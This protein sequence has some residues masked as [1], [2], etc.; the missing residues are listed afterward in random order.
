MHHPRDRIVNITAFVIPVVNHWLERLS[1][2]TCISIHVHG[3][4]LTLNLLIIKTYINFNLYYF[5]LLSVGQISFDLM[6]NIYFYIH[7]YFLIK[8]C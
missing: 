3:Y 2:K 8:I 7:W 5:Q 6:N 1:Y 4:S